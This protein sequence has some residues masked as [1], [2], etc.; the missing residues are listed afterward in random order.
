MRA[1]HRPLSQASLA[2][3]WTSTA[4]RSTFVHVPHLPTLRLGAPLCL[5]LEFLIKM[6]FDE[7][8]CH[9]VS[10]LDGTRG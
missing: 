7:M 2:P 8:Q 3:H 9:V 4:L 5:D 1:T 6:Q 10:S